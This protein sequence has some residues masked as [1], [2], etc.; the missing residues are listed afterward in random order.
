MDGRY[1]ELKQSQGFHWSLSWHMAMEN[2]LTH[3]ETMASMCI[4]Q[5]YDITFM[6]ISYQ[7]NHGAQNMSFGE[8]MLLHFT[9][10]FI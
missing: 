7:I 1:F 3:N 9:G 10:R 8:Q 2:I 6:S 4:S 5:W